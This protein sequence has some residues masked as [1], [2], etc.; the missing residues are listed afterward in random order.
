LLSYQPLTTDPLVT[1]EM[2]RLIQS[3]LCVKPIRAEVH[4]EESGAPGAAAK[5]SSRRLA[6][7]RE[8]Q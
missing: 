2:R 4:L 6:R 5:D 1:A 7:E 8:G 3:G